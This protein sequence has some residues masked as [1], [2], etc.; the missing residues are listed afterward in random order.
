ME[1]FRYWIPGWSLVGV[2]AAPAQPAD[3]S[4]WVR[5]RSGL[6]NETGHVPSLRPTHFQLNRPPILTAYYPEF[7]SLALIHL[8]AVVA[9]GPDFAVT[10]RQSVRKGRRAGIWGAIG[11]G[12]GIS[13][14]VLYTLL[15][16]GALLHATPSL[17]ALAKVAGA[18]Y[19]LYLVFSFLRNARQ[20]KPVVDV[21]ADAATVDGAWRSFVLG[22]MTN[23][24]NPKA[25]LFF[26]AI[27]TTVVSAAT[28]LSVQA[29]YGAWMCLVNAGWF[30]LV[31]ML[32]AQPRVRQRF[33]RIGGRLEAVIAVVFFALSMRLLWDVAGTWLGMAST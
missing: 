2:Q 7:F 11:I 9:P 22:F 21:A 25:T 23:A 28:P 24:T 20:E 26:L 6:P 3:A 8:L 10:V 5:T 33:L 14:H 16:V 17:M 15:G 29:L 27:F 31:A 32:F 30:V 18:G 13:V 4:D 19:L 12:A 1:Q